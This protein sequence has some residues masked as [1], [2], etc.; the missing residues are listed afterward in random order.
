[1][2][3]CLACGGPILSGRLHHFCCAACQHQAR[4]DIK[5]NGIK[6][7]CR[8]CGIEFVGSRFAKKSFCCKNCEKQYGKLHAVIQPALTGRIQIKS[9]SHIHT[10]GVDLEE[11]EK[12]PGVEPVGGKRFWTTTNMHRERMIGCLL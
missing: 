6:K 5:L 9:T 1:M 4:R 3:T 10:F 2:K 7:I 11:K 12:F 8:N